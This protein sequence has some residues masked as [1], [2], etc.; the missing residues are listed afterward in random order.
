MRII[1]LSQFCHGAIAKASIV[2]MSSTKQ[3]TCILISIV[4]AL[5]IDLVLIRMVL[6]L[7]RY[8]HIGF[9][10]GS[11]WESTQNLDIRHIE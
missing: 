4:G 5:C 11:V 2:S 3:G 1:L 9:D 10:L 7:S 8:S 6:A